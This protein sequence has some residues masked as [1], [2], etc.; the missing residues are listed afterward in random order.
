VE[1]GGEERQTLLFALALQ[2]CDCSLIVCVCVCE[3]SV[4]V[5]VFYSLQFTVRT[6]GAWDWELPNKASYH[7]TVG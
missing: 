2:N 6:L 3:T 1:A 5:W 4:R 7:E